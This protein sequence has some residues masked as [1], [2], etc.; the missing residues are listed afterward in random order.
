MTQE[1]SKKKGVQEW[2]VEQVCE[3]LK[4]IGMEEYEGVF[5]SNKIRGY[6]LLELTQD[7]LEKMGI[8]AVG[9]LIEILKEIEELK[10]ASEGKGDE[11]TLDQVQAGPIDNQARLAHQPHAYAS[12]APLSSPPEAAPPTESPWL[13][14]VDGESQGDG[15]RGG[16]EGGRRVDDADVYVIQGW[17]H[18]W[19]LDAKDEAE[20]EF[21]KAIEINRECVDGL[22]GLALCHASGHKYAE[23]HKLLYQ[24]LAIHP[25]HLLCLAVLVRCL[26]EECQKATNEG[27]KAAKLQQLTKYFELA[28]QESEILVRMNPSGTWAL[29]WTS[30][31]LFWH[32]EHWKAVECL[33][34]LLAIDD[35]HA[36]GWYYKGVC[37]TVA[38]NK[39]QEAIT[40]FDPAIRIDPK[41]A[42][43]WYS[44]GECLRRLDRREEALPCF[45]EANRLD[46]DNKHFAYAMQ[47]MQK[48][49]IIS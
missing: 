27:E 18:F 15:L 41:L 8:T 6:S 5:R 11:T 9:D 33:D 12:P 22:A 44:K 39:H 42:K 20:V 48:S 30:Y 47:Q 31:C 45:V 14:T 34:R 29:F 32:D 7:L 1:E 36:L 23:S 21:K 35:H 26:Y 3:W 28:M 40:C 19:R 13:F 37:L 46:P 10:R 24:A 43:A 16:E 2:S 49:C 17:E 25:N 4:R 38:L